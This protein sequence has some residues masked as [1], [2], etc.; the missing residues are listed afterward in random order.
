MTKKVVAICIFAILRLI[1][2]SVEIVV[3]S[4]TLVLTFTPTLIDSLQ[5]MS[6]SERW[7]TL[8]LLVM[9]LGTLNQF[10]SWLPFI[11][12]ERTDKN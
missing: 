11:P 3:G 12:T 8:A 10:W 6:V 5:P 4:M 1:L 7:L 2:L 9:L